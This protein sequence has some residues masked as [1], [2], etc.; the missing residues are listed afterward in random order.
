MTPVNSSVALIRRCRRRAL[1][2]VGELVDDSVVEVEVTAIGVEFEDR[3]VSSAVG[4]VVE[5]EVAVVAV[6]VVDDAAVDARTPIFSTTQAP[7]GMGLSRCGGGRWRPSCL[8]C[9]V[10]L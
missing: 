5:R 8:V 3:R 2:V 4:V 1:A 6:V 7:V 9:C 10:G